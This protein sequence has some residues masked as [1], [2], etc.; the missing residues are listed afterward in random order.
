LKN[1]DIFVKE[2]EQSKSRRKIRTRAAP[3]GI[4]ALSFASSLHDIR[5]S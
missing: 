2:R 4:D 1:A 5:C 3:W